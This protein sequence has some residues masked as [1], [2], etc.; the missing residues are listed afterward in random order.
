M[1]EKIKNNLDNYLGFNSDRL[2]K[3]GTYDIMIFGGAIRDSIAGQKIHD[4]DILISPKSRPYIEDILVSEGYIMDTKCKLDISSLYFGM[5]QIINEPINYIKEDKVVQLIRP[6]TH[7]NNFIYHFNELL[8]N[9]DLS[10]CGVSYDSKNIYENIK[11]SIQ[12]CLNKEFLVY[13][14]NSM[15]NNRRVYNRIDKMLNRGWSEIKIRDLNK[16]RKSKLNSIHNIID[17]SYIK[18]YDK[19]RNYAIKERICFW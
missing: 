1:L 13:S 7:S 10:C 4:I 9:V 18:T 17:F 5:E 6:V 14:E 8:K 15:F 12:H 19:E 11:D 16:V 3:L 2:F